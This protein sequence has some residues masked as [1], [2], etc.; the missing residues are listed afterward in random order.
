LRLK[1]K[2]FYQMDGGSLLMGV[3]PYLSH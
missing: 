3:L 2:F 1:E